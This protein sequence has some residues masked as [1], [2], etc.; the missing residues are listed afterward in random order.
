MNEREKNGSELNRFCCR[1]KRES[2]DVPVKDNR[3]M[4]NGILQIAR[5]V[6]QWRELPETY[7]LWQS[8]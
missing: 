2:E 6:A 5:S 8:V 4:L 1:K 7:G 3:T